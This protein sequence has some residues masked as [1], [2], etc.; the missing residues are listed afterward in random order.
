MSIC[1]FGLRPYASV[2]SYGHIEM[3]SSSNQTLFLG[4]LDQV[5]NQRFVHI[6]LLVTDNKPSLINDHRNYFMI[7][8]H[9][10]ME[11]S[12]VKLAIS[13][14]TVRCI[15]NCDNRLGKIHFLVIR[16][17]LHYNMILTTSLPSYYLHITSIRVNVADR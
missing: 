11:P 2:N 14:S 8:L 17:N 10:G 9:E 4:K 3:V 6:L 15:N 16:N 12:R 13:G 5:V 7:N 1:W